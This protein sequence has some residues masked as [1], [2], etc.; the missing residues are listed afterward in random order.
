MNNLDKQR[1]AGFMAALADNFNATVTKRKIQ[2]YFDFLDDLTIEQ[3][4]RAVRE[5]IATDRFFPTIGDIRRKTL[6]SVEVKAM[7]AWSEVVNA[8]GKYS[9]MPN[10]ADITIKTVIDKAF[11]GWD[12]FRWYLTPSDYVLA[13]DRQYFIEAYKLY[14]N[15]AERKKLTESK[16]NL[17]E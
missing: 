17:L 15:L 2:L 14:Y 3:V 13:K 16:T 8:G 11:G 10:F 12:K 7:E 1:F 6:Q 5:I 9:T 4:G